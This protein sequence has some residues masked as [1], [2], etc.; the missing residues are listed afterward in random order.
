ML[1]VNTLACGANSGYT[2]CISINIMNTRHI[3]LVVGFVI[4]LALVGASCSKSTNSSTTNVPAAAATV[5]IANMAF[6]PSTVTV[7]VGETVTWTNHDGFSHTVTGDAGGPNSGTIAAGQSY[8]FTFA[9]TGTFA[10]HCAIH[11]SMV[12]TV[13]VTE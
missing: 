6:T 10:Y 2:Q 8:S 11:P 13:I 12:G 1:F 5:T 3:T 7:K 9:T 4:S